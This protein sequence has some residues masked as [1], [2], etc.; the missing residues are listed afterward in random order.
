MKMENGNDRVEK[1]KIKKFEIQKR[2]GN[3]RR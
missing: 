1:Q 3:K 2:S